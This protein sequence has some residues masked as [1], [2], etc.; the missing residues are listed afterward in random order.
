MTETKNISK[1]KT[2]CTWKKLNSKEE[3]KGDKEKRESVLRQKRGKKGTINAKYKK[4]NK[5]SLI[6]NSRR[7]RP[8]CRVY[9]NTKF[10]I[11]NQRWLRR[12]LSLTQSLG[13]KIPHP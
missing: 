5:Q 12:K 3:R 6:L 8:D 10:L 11:I 2:N 1:E 13:A 9:S 4:E 7:P